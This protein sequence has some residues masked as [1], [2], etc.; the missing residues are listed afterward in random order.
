M[1]AVETN[2]EPA[3]HTS[4]ARSAA[5][6]AED[7][8]ALA[9]LNWQLFLSEAR[10]YVSGL[11]AVVIMVATAAGLILSA[12]LL[13]LVAIAFK[14]NAE[15]MSPAESCGLV[16]LATIVGAAALLFW[17]RTRIQGMAGAFIRSRAEVAQNVAW[18]KEI[19]AAR[20]GDLSDR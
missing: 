6:L 15:G 11:V 19:I 9:G 7:L 5:R 3:G 1:I 17:S 2:H 13:A 18:I 8:V 14:L 4:V 20:K 10:E 16:A 12:V